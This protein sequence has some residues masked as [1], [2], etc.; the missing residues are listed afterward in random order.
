[1]NVLKGFAVL[2]GLLAV[3]NFIKPLELASNHGFVFM[4]RR[5]T[6]APNVIC[7]LA[8]AGFLAA[9]A[10]ALWDERGEAL[11]L[12][13]AYAVFVSGNLALFFLRSPELAKESV[14]FGV[15]YS[16]V[17][18]GVTWGAVV[19][20]TRQGITRDAPQYD[21]GLRVFAML[22]ALMALSNFLKPFSTFENTGFVLFGAR[23]TG[24]ANMVAGPIFGAFLAAYA[25]AIWTRKSVAVPMGVAY[26]LYVIANLVLW[27]VR[28]PDGANMS[29]VLSILYLTIAVGVSSGSAFLLTRVRERL[30]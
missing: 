27:N 20:M 4:G 11:P 24:S 25:A 18:T 2:F 1:M 12:G 7:S 14:L 29:L 22:F 28:K 21:T 17:A 19:A 13:I 6:G 30:T 15:V 10:R 26:A 9:Y 5:Y 23:L 16:L 8:F 3:S